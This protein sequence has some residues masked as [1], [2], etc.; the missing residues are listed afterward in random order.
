VFCDEFCD[1]LREEKLT[2]AC[3]FLEDSKTC[4]IVRLS[5]I[6]RNSPLK[7]TL[8]AWFE[9]SELFWWAISR[10][11]DLLPG[12]IENIKNI[13]Q[14]FL[15]RLFPR[16]KLHIIEDEHIHLT[17]SITELV[18]T[19]SL[20]TRDI[21]RDKLVSSRIH[22]AQRLGTGVDDISNALQEVRLTQTNIAIEIEWIVGRSGLAS[23]C[24]TCGMRELRRGSYD[25]IG[26]LVPIRDD[27][28]INSCDYRNPFYL[29]FFGLFFSFAM[30]HPTI[31]HFS[32]WSYFDPII[33][34]KIHYFN[35]GSHFLER[36]LDLIVEFFGEIILVKRRHHTQSNTRLSRIHEGKLFEIRK[37]ILFA[38]RQRHILDRVAKLGKLENCRHE[39]NQLKKQFFGYIVPPIFTEI[40]CEVKRKKSF[41]SF[42]CI[43][44]LVDI[45]MGQSTKARP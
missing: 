20:D 19:A 26:E 22:H 43:R 23:D 42:Y 36:C 31:D 5:E 14:F 41:D 11:D 3:F 34:R 15:C 10:E 44:F 17:V 45:S 4:L 9:L 33:Y 1:I 21:I 18:D 6:Y 13:V 8:Q 37:K 38:D 25:K 40:F 30:E 7:P 2:G 39:N 35:T 12:F 16:E 27:S 32:L 29:L 28:T 24:L